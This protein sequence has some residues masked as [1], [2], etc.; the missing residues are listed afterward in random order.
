MAFWKAARAVEPR[1][2]EMGSVLAERA[3]MASVVELDEAR[4]AFRRTC[5]RVEE[6]ERGDADAELGI[7]DAGAKLA[8]A[9]ARRD[10]L[11]RRLARGEALGPEAMAE[12]RAAIREAEAGIREAE[13]SLESRREL[14]E[15][16][17]EET[18]R[19][20]Q[21][22]DRALRAEIDDRNR[23]LGETMQEVQKELDRI[24]AVHTQL[25]NLSTNAQQAVR[26]AH[27]HRATVNE[28]EDV[29]ADL[30]AAL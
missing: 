2:V 19:A 27:G 20:R 8:A 26:G 18:K 29:L 25:L 13:A 15:F 3:P 4:A 6:I 7:A 17:E 10:E 9:R 24:G 28:L 30:E 1:T 23:R 22:L 11:M 14:L 16:A 21:R 5:Q 12:A